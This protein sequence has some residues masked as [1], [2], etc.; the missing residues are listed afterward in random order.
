MDR[1]V[2]IAAIGSLPVWSLAAIAQQ[3]PFKLSILLG[4]SPDPRPIVTALQQGLRD[5]GYVE[6]RNIAFET[7]SGEANLEQMML[8]A[9]QLAA[10]QPDVVFAYPTP[11]ATATMLVK[12]PAPPTPCV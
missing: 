6:G 4:N 7:R 10:L 2:L 9:R 3:K 8:M 12:V 5:F 1:R 11:A